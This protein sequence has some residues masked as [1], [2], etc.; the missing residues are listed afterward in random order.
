MRN[1]II[2]AF[3]SIG[4]ALAACNVLDVRPQSAI[5]AEDAFKDKGGIER[6]ILGAYI[7]FQYLSYYGR[8][9]LIL[10]DLA[11]D[12]LDLTGN[13]TGE[14]V[15]VDNNNILPENG[16]IGNIWASAYES[17]NNANNVI[18]KV[19]QMADM[20]D[21]EKNVALGELYFIRALNYFNLLNYFGAVPI[22]LTP[23]VGTGGVNIP[24]NPVNEVYDQIV[25]DLE[26]AETNLPAS[27]VKVRASKYAA[28]A[29]LARVHLYNKNYAEASVKA[30]DVIDNG[31]Y[32][33]LND[34][35]Q[36]FKD[37]S[38]ESIFEIDFVVLARNR[39]AEQ[40]FPLTLNGKREVAPS[41]GIVSAYEP[42]DQR[43][44]K[45]LAFDSTNFNPQTLQGLEPYAIKYSD[46][47]TGAQNVIVLRLAEMYLIRAEAQAELEGSVTAIQADLN[48]IRDRA[49]LTGSTTNSYTN[50][51]LEIERERRVE[52]AFEGQRWFDLVRTGR[53]TA[54]LP[55]V[56]TVNKTLFP[57]PLSEI[58]TN[59][60]PDMKQ[61]PGY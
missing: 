57:I 33:L 14:Y 1:I 3:I 55:N 38:A 13:T 34:Y 16:T 23:T 18:A 24:R 54:I 58:L 31:G 49:D 56:T 12:N 59:T 20:T 45:S 29:L 7:P 8:S 4:I 28:K 44:L 27:T 19:P 39:I 36:I 37:G 10:S 32:Q 53:A 26:F 60:N 41:S 48:K 47:A 42:D 30:T 22:K 43:F 52:F 50:L 15:E 21:D 46:L 11:A 25:D 61:N 6:G 9:Y 5:P 35:S 2:I 17:I 51:L 40:N